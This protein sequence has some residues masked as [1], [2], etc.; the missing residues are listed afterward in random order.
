MKKIISF[1]G[2][3]ALAGVTLLFVGC[4][5]ASY[6]NKLSVYPFKTALVQYELSGNTEG[7]QSLFIRGDEKAVST[8]ITTP[9]QEKNTFELYLG[10]TKY[11]ANLDKMTAVKA[12]NTQYTDMLELS[13]EEQ[14]AYLIKKSL[15]LKESAELPEPIIT[16]TVAGREC[17]VYDIPNVGSACIWNGIVLQKE[18]TLAGITNKTI[19]VNVETDVEIPDERFELPAGVIVTNN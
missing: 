18:I 17:D 7:D 13:P 11:I 10:S 8:F 14:E 5:D 1:I 6:P 9:G 15:G 3:L 16:S 19:A 2:L 12:A 4:D